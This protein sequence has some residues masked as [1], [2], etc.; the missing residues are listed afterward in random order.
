M[1]KGM[2]IPSSDD[3]SWRF[4]VERRVFETAEQY[5]LTYGDAGNPAESIEDYVHRQIGDAEKY[6][7][8][9][10]GHLLTNMTPDEIRLRRAA[11]HADVTLTPEWFTGEPHAAPAAA[12]EVTTASEVLTPMVTGAA[13]AAAPTGE[14]KK[15]TLEIRATDGGTT[16]P[17]PQLMSFLYEEGKAPETVN[18]QYI[19]TTGK[20]DHWV[21]DGATP[22]G[23][24]TGNPQTVTMDMSHIIVAVF[25]LNPPPV[26][27]WKKPEPTAPEP[28]PESQKGGAAPAP[29]TSGAEGSTITE[30]GLS[31]PSVPPATT[32]AFTRLH[33]IIFKNH[34]A[35]FSLAWRVRD[36]LMSPNLQNLLHP[37]V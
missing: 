14:I 3:V 32:Y 8:G 18:V 2:E 17:K 22:F 5:W 30:G 11:S 36:K 23:N 21:L 24:P 31:T 16:D 25:E 19:E 6:Y 33:G 1:S 37:L 13:P 35:L 12:P 27:T 20:F 7:L 15:V 26:F 4:T 28:T 34:D 29:P 10:K 9:Y